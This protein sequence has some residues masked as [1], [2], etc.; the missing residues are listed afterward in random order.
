M[1]AAAAAT[2]AYSGQAA[3]YCSRPGG[4]DVQIF[5]FSPTARG[6]GVSIF[7]TRISRSLKLRSNATGS[8]RRVDHPSVFPQQ[9]FKKLLSHP[10]T[11]FISGRDLHQ[12]VRLLALIGLPSPPPNYPFAVHPAARQQA[13]QP[14]PAPSRPVTW[15]VVA[16]WR[17]CQKCITSSIHSQYFLLGPL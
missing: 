2:A 10:V 12:R 6:G 4:L 17:C 5:F 13:R 15:T 7:R 16:L 14:P 8:R 1:H 9:S 11:F 3:R